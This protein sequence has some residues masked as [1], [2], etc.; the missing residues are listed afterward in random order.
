MQID[1]PDLVHQCE[2]EI[3]YAVVSP[4]QYYIRYA[5]FYV[6]ITIHRGFIHLFFDAEG[7][8]LGSQYLFYS[9]LRGAIVM[10]GSYQCCN[11]LIS[12]FLVEWL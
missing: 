7:Y 1:V 6:R 10:Q 9:I 3:V 2:S 12:S 5:V 8:S 4:C 11:H